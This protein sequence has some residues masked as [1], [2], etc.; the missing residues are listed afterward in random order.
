M[1]PDR[2][3]PKLYEPERY[4]PG[5]RAG[6]ESAG[7]TS[8]SPRNEPSASPLVW[9][10]AAELRERGFEPV[11]WEEEGEVSSER[12]APPPGRGRPP[13]EPGDRSSS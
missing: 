10:S 1:A 9:L 8:S 13:D 3:V 12:V 5:R 6:S 11:E 2:V 4:E 7:G